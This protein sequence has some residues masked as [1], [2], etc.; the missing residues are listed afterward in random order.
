MH[1][2]RKAKNRIKSDANATAQP[3]SINLRAVEI[4]YV[5]KCSR[6][7]Q[8]GYCVWSSQVYLFLPR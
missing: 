6:W 4:A 1:I 8:R 7:K 3:V 2:A 5:K